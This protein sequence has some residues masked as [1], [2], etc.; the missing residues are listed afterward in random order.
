[1]LEQEP[2]S[3]Q[4]E[5]CPANVRIVDVPIVVPEGITGIRRLTHEE[6]GHNYIAP[7]GHDSKPVE[8]P[9]VK[10]KKPNKRKD[11]VQTKIPQTEG[12][13]NYSIG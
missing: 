10:N 12:Q 13:S 4:M 11:G 3:T 8:Y 2:T 9:T 1:M 6:L 5:T 7:P